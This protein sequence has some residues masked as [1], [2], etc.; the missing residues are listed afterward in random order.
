M[1]IAF[2]DAK[3]VGELLNLAALEK[4]GQVTFYQ[5][6][7]PAETLAR[8][9]DQDIVITNKVVLDRTILE[10][11]PHL[12][13]ICVAATGTNNVDLVAA[14]EIGITVKNVVD[15]S[16]NSVAQL[17]FALL[18]QLIN[19]ISYFDNYVKQGDYARSDIFT[20]LQPPYWE[21]SGKQFGIIGLGNIGR[22]VAKI[23]AAF[24]ATVVYYSA[25]GK[26]NNP[27]YQRLELEEFLASSDIISIHAPLNEYTRNLINYE[28]LQQMKRSALLIN[29]GRGGIVHEADLA[30]ALDE[31]LI[32]GA[33]VDVFETEPIKADNPLLQIKEPAKL[34]LTPHIAWAS[35][36][37]RTL[38]L[39]KVQQNIREFLAQQ[40][41]SV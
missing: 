29:V 35:L 19:Q 16:T 25:S 7:T 15:Y 18:L 31:N 38:L 13:L 32:A 1:N 5:T 12:K 26:N 3:T 20:H 28:R 10:S 40:E 17:T 30:W 4:Y 6:T 41:H 36:E 33:G 21:I 24:G 2:L 27:D 11:C 9:Q 14:R 23:A 37:A 39:D 34:V 22:Q 8:V